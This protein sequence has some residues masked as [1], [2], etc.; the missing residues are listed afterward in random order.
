MILKPG[1]SAG[2]IIWLARACGSAAGSVTTI[3][4]AK[5]APSAE[6][7]NHFLPLIT[8]ESPSRTAV[9]AIQTGFDPG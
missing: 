8:Y 9:V 7:V 1:V 3:T 5:L 2:T 6:D 4:M